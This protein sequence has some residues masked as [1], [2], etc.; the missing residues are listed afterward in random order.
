MGRFQAEELCVNMVQTSP[1]WQKSRQYAFV[2][3]NNNSLL[4]SQMVSSEGIQTFLHK[5][6][7]MC[8]RHFCTEIIFFSLAFVLS[9][10]A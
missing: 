3:R 8:E 1:V 2:R 10:V 9:A 5:P 4:H 6:K 7:A